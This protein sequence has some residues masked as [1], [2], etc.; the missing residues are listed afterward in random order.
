MLSGWKLE[1]GSWKLYAFL[2]P[3]ILLGDLFSLTNNPG[4]SYYPSSVA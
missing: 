1:A 4:D 3:L 2:T